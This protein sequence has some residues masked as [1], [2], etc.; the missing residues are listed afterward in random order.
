MAAKKLQV[1]SKYNEYDLDGDGI[2]GNSDLL[3]FL[4]ET[5]QQSECHPT[6]FNFDGETDIN[7]L[8]LFLNQYGYDCNGILVEDNFTANV[9]EIMDVNGL[10]KIGS[11]I[12]FDLTGRKVNDKGRLAP[13][14]YIVV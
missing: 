2:T 7:D 14:I 5:G 6:D 13:G 11:P 4:S 1:E 8:T 9:T 12:Y 3:I 10:C